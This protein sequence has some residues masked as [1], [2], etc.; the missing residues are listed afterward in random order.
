[1]ARWVHSTWCCVGSIEVEREASLSL[2]Q[3]RLPVI[4][5]TQSL[6]QPRERERERGVQDVKVLFPLFLSPVSLL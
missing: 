1:M 5:L 6:Q 4:L 2:L 3:L